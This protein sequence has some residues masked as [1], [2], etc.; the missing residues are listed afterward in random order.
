MLFISYSIQGDRKTI[1]KLGLPVSDLICNCL[2]N[3]V[4]LLSFFPHYFDLHS[5][6]FLDQRFSNFRSL[7]KSS[8]LSYQVILVLDRE[9]DWYRRGVREAIYIRVNKP[10]LNR[11]QGR[12]RL[13]HSWD[14]L[15][16][17]RVS[18]FKRPRPRDCSHCDQG[19]S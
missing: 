10:N 9:K 14:P 13:S 5:M 4:L 8:Y 6:L 16:Q 19:S 1:T 11:D 17:S 15:L 12:T 2:K 18:E 3:N 7:S